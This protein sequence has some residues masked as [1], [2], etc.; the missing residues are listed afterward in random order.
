MQWFDFFLKKV[1]PVFNIL[2]EC[3]LY[4]CITLWKY[5]TPLLAHYQLDSY[6][7]QLEKEKNKQV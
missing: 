5:N 6:T 2:N 4:F 3:F 7:M 1:E